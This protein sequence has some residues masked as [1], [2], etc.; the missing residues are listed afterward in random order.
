MN[1][2]INSLFNENIGLVKSIVNKLDYGYVD[3]GDLLQVGLTG[4]YEA[5]LNYSEEKKQTFKK[6]CIIYI[7]SKIKKELRNNKLIVIPKEI[8]SIKKKLNN[9]NLENKS[10]SELSKCL[11]T[12]KE[13]IIL[14]LSE[15]D[16]VISLN[17]EVNDGFKIEY[18][19]DNNQKDIILEYGIDKLDPLSK[20]VIILKYYKSYSQKEISKMLNCSQAKVSRIEK[21]AL[22]NIKKWIS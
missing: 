8:I 19:K 22:N 15:I 14:S 13:N 12:S 17:K 21:D 7:L 16:N 10:I 20:K 9:I 1:A 18:I 5:C 6:Y 11:E 4:L 2:M 3:K